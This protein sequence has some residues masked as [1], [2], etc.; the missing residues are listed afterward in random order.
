MTLG[1]G[2]AVLYRVKTRVHV[3]LASRGRDRWASHERDL[4]VSGPLGF[5]G[6]CERQRS[7]G[8]LFEG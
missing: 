1:G 8:A 3:P 6:H 2:V 4:A 7:S 5:G